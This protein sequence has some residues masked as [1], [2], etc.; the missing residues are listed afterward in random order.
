MN[1]DEHVPVLIVGGGYA[2]LTSSLFLSHHGVSSL[3]VDR[4]PGVSIQGRARGINQ[5]TMELYRPLGLEIAIQRAGEPFDGDA[6]VARCQTL[7]GEWEWIVT[8]Q[9]PRSWP[10]LSAG[11][12]CMAD[13]S[14]VEPILIDAARSAGA[15]QRFN[16]E[17]V[18]LK[19]DDD[20]VSAVIA[21]RT[22]GRHYTVRA[23]YVIAA[24]GHR[25]AIR[26]QLSIARP[27]PGITQH[28]VSIVFDADLT[29]V[30][31]QRALFWIVMNP[32][33]GFG[34]FVTTATPGRWAVSVTYDPNQQSSES[35]TPERCAKLARAVVGDPGLV[36]EIVDIGFWQQAIGVAKSYRRGRVFL[37]GDSAHVWQRW[38]PTPASKTPTTWPGS[39]PR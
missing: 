9:A 7:A 31:A 39:S 8:E 17:L 34:G 35:F 29:D 36:V 19:P 32:Q 37:V 4:H 28:W 22:S 5:R 16:S 18:S 27:G 12:F 26:E 33:I 25:G 21:D 11:E 23:G 15:E 2:G 6:G 3:L 38:A 13:Q 20:G 14:T 10:A 24:D 1:F 30:I